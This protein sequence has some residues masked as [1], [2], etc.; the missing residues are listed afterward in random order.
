M[1]GL[2]T[3]G[4]SQKNACSNT[5]TPFFDTQFYTH[6]LKMPWTCLP[7]TQFPALQLSFS[8]I[9][10]S[11]GHGLPTQLGRSRGMVVADVFLVGCRWVD[12]I[13]RWCTTLG[14]RKTFDLKSL[15]LWGPFCVELIW[16]GFWGGSDLRPPGH[17]TSPDFIYDCGRWC[18]WFQGMTRQ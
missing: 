17:L 3:F 12:S 7:L 1:M 4:S 13:D 11:W 14:K 2:Q 6:G 16:F 15:R 9:S 10:A 5:N 18:W 8:F